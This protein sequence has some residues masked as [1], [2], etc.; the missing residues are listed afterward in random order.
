MKKKHIKRIGREIENR[1]KIIQR[2]KKGRK[3]NKMKE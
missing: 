2:K 3:N 1:K